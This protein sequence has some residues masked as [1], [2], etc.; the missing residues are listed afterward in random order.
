M[1]GLFS[2]I[3][4]NASVS[5]K[6]VAIGITELTPALIGDLKRAEEFADI[7][8]VGA[9]VRE[10]ESI[11]IETT[12]GNVDR[13]AS[14]CLMSLVKG[15]E[16]AAIVRGQVYYT[17]Y[18]NSMNAHFGFER[19]VMCPYLLRDRCDNEWFITPVVH[20][21]DASISGRCY[22]AS[23]TAR[24]CRKLVKEVVVIGVLAPDKRKEMG[25]DKAVD[26]G[27]REAE[28][29]VERLQADGLDARLVELRIDL[30]AANSHIVVPMD[31]IVGNFVYR[32]LGSLGKA[33]LVGGFTLTNRF[34][35]I[36]T[37]QS[38]EGYSHAI[39]AAVAFANLGGMPVEDYAR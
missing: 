2:A 25:Y 6:R 39:E 36:D 13:K 24:I 30:A 7:V 9:S 16:V 10:F 29:I 35:S 3:T 34:V 27:I 26:R 32:S 19:D 38:Q 4:A 37:S 22:L 11:S 5:R 8:T 17:D 15:N 18:H 14:D 31:G 21:D 28:A 12:G 33:T 20:H 1:T 23:Q